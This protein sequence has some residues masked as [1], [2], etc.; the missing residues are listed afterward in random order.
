MSLNSYLYAATAKMF[1][2]LVRVHRARCALRTPTTSP[3]FGAS[4]S[5]QFG[6]LFKPKSPPNSFLGFPLITCSDS[7]FR[8][9]V[10]IPPFSCSDSPLSIFWIPP[11]QFLDPP[12]CLFGFPLVNFWIPPFARLSG[13]PLLLA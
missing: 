2:K 12:F 5:R 7:L 1:P 13:S 9:L 8:S 11:C 3:S 10:R 6:S 4:C